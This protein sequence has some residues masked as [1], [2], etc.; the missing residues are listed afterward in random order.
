MSDQNDPA[1][2]VV[3]HTSEKDI[4]EMELQ[5]KWVE[6]ELTKST[7]DHLFVAGHCYHPILIVS[8]CLSYLHFLYYS[9]FPLY[10]IPICIPGSPPIICFHFL[11]GIQAAQWHGDK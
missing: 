3:P 5:W 1:A 4:A 11:S 8:F 7:A 9:L 6:E 2:Y 10:I